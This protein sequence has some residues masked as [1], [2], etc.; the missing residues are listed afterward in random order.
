MTS[1]AEFESLC[2]RFVQRDGVSRG[3]MMSSPGLKYGGKVFA[4]FHHDK[5]VFKLGEGFDIK[6]FGV[7]DYSLLNPFK[8][9]PPLRAWF[10]VPASEKQYW[11]GLAERAL[12]F[13]SK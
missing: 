10:E 7:S 11:E 12:Q 9:K 8:T 13:V 4:F 2:E 1:R 6:A 3:K 5:M